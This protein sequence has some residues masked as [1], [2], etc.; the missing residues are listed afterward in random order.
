MSRNDSGGDKKGC[1][2]SQAFLKTPHLAGDGG[3]V[4]MTSSSHACTLRVWWISKQR[5][6]Y[7]NLVP[8][9]FVFSFAVLSLPALYE[10]CCLSLFIIL[11]V[12]FM[13]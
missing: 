6:S 2:A 7:P 1:G 4:T 9:P 5:V 12:H 11:S 10:S 13:L 3:T 8:L